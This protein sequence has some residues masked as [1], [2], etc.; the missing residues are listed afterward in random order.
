MLGMLREPHSG[1]DIKKTFEKSLRSFWR[2][3]LSQI[4]PLLQKM[5]D[6]GLLTSK[7]GAS[8]T[9]APV[10]GSL[11]PS[12]KLAMT[13]LMVQE[14][15]V[16]AY[17]QKPAMRAVIPSEMRKVGDIGQIV[18]CDESHVCVISRFIERTQHTTAYA[19]VSINCDAIGQLSLPRLER[20][21]SLDHRSAHVSNDFT[22]ATMFSAVK[23]KCSIRTGPGADSP[24]EFMPTIFPSR[25]TS[26]RQ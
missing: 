22:V 2:A 21:V 6:E 5:E 11:F 26:L 19:A 4:Y 10:R 12:R 13:T 20:R 15:P 23:P 8:G 18:D 9:H 3:E 17:S 25:P 24:K 1:Y 14:L 7:A 16:L